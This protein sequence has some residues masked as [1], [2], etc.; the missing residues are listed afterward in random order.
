M[1]RH[2]LLLTSQGIKDREGNY[3]EESVIFPEDAIKGLEDSLELK[4]L[5]DKVHVEVLSVSMRGYDPSLFRTRYENLENLDIILYG[6]MDSQVLVKLIQMLQ[7]DIQFK[8]R[9]GYFCLTKEKILPTRSLWIYNPEKPSFC[10][11]HQIY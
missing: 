5:W 3:V 6:G 9:V 2:A 4:Y 8:W 7:N 1:E 10:C 11:L